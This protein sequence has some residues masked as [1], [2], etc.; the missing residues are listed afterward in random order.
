MKNT[1]KIETTAKL[2]DN[3]LG[4][5]YTINTVSAKKLSSYLK[6]NLTK[7]GINLEEY[8]REIDSHNREEKLEKNPPLEIYE[9]QN[10][11]LLEKTD[12]EYVLLDGFRRLLFY[13]APEHPIQVRIYHTD[14]ISDQNIL[15]LLVYLNHFKFYN[16]TGKYYDRGFALALK[17][18]FDLNITNFYDGFDGYLSAISAIRDYGW[19]TETKPTQKNEIIKNRILSTSFIEDMKLLDVMY[20]KGNM[21]NTEFGALLY[22]NRTEN[23]GV[24]FDKFV[25]I[26]DTPNIKKLLVSFAKIGDNDGERSKKLINELIQEY[27]NAF[28]ILLGKEAKKSYTDYLNEARELSKNIK[29]DTKWTKISGSKSIYQIEREIL[30]YYEKNKKAPKFKVVIFPVKGLSEGAKESLPT[31]IY[32]FKMT[33]ITN[34]GRPTLEYNGA[35]VRTTRHSKWNNIPDYKSVGKSGFYH[36]DAEVYVCF[37]L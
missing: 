22:F 31:G 18:I 32:D 37:E 15:K 35:S 33:S 20:N 29:A 19:K 7:K 34:S 27:K 2:H 21:T 3:F 16:G 28:L 23:P 24:D 36:N 11:F 8:N 12:G 10:F 17:V 5:D 25:T 1:F 14:D 9:Y 13:T 30:S 4:V 26:C 6:G